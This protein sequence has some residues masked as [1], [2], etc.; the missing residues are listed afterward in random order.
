MLRC[1]TYSHAWDAVVDPND[2][3]ISGWLSLPS[4]EALLSLR[5]LRCTTECKDIID[6]RTG[7]LVRRKY[8]YPPGYLGAREVGRLYISDLRVELAKRVR[9]FSAPEDLIGEVLKRAGQ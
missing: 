1:R 4:V 7:R 9:I 2:A 3:L 6:T 5:C 8:V